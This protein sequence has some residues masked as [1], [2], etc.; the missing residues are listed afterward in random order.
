MTTPKDENGEPVADPEDI[1]ETVRQRDALVII[2]SDD[3]DSRVAKLSRGLLSNHLVNQ[4]DLALIDLALFRP[5]GDA[6]GKCVVVPSM[7]NMIQSEPR[8]VV[9][10]VV[11]GKTPSA[12]VVVEVIGDH[13]E[14][15]DHPPISARQRWDEKRFFENLEAG[16]AP[17]SVRQLASQLRELARSFPESVV[18]AWGTG[19]EGCMVIKRQGGGLI[20]VYG[21]GKIRFRPPKF[22][23]ALG[24]KGGGEYRRRLEQMVPDAMRMEYPRLAPAE[25]AKVAPALFKLVE[26]T[27]ARVERKT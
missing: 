10:V 19:K 27:L 13:P 7:R 17:Q 26:E 21:S 8:Q 16:N 15:G 4:W 1:R 12:P 24:A 23:R 5:V 3:V 2:A 18:L 22:G 6:S 11:D 9:R 20:E 25:A 14:T